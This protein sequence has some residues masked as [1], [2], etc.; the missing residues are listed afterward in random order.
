MHNGFNNE[1]GSAEELNEMAESNEIG[2]IKFD[3]DDQ[4]EKLDTDFDESEELILKSPEADIENF[5]VSSAIAAATS[6]VEGIID[7]FEGEK[8]IDQ[9]IG[10]IKAKNQDGTGFI[11]NEVG[12]ILTASAEK[13][14][15]S[16]TDLGCD[17]PEKLVEFGI[18]SCDL[19]VAYGKGE[20]GLNEM[21]YDLGEN[22]AGTLGRLE[23]FGVGLAAELLTDGVLKGAPAVGETVGY[24]IAVGAYRTLVDVGGVIL[25]EH[26]DEIEQLKDS[27]KDMASNAINKAAELGGDEAAEK[28]KSSIVEFNA[29]LELPDE[30]I[31]DD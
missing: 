27:M 8:T 28:M 22:L 15:G 16:L 25:E 2:E 17:I 31:F 20:I 11:S 10:D 4:E 3:F 23:G 29:E 13:L 7:C 19:V 5:D 24:T 6:T 1:L 14:L 30:I 12:A 9:A 18:S 26:S 21:A